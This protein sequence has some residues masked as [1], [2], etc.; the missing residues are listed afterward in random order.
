M[1]VKL[2]NSIILYL[3]NKFAKPKFKK[4]IQQ[5][6]QQT[7]RLTVYCGV[8]VAENTNYNANTCSI[9]GNIKKTANVCN[10][11][12]PNTVPIPVAENASI[13]SQNHPTTHKS[14]KRGRGGTHQQRHL[15]R[16]RHLDAPRMA[17]RLARVLAQRPVDLHVAPGDEAESHARVADDQ[18]QVDDVHGV[19]RLHRHADAGRRIV[20]D[21]E[22]RQRRHQHRV[23]PAA[24]LDEQRAAH[25]DALVQVHRVRDG[26]P[27]LQRDG[28]QREHGQVAGEDG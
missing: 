5:K 19:A 15:L 27:A 22:Q 1:I 4:K 20:A 10:V 8:C 21:A 16:H 14:R 9:P 11:E 13:L 17:V 3:N 2:R 18:H 25:A 6:L 28:A 23:R 12:K 24:Q 26:E 7:T